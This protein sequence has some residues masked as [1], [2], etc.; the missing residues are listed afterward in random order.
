VDKLVPDVLWALVEPADRLDWSRA[1]VDSTSV[2]ARR[3]S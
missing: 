3:R 1:S 2:R